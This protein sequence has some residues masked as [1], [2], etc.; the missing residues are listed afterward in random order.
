VHL[1]GFVIR[2]FVTM[3]GHMNVTMHG[4]MNV[5]LCL[6]YHLQFCPIGERFFLSFL[7]FFTPAPHLYEVKFVNVIAFIRLRVL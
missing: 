5:K 2:E 4:H 1:V 7:S 6:T 3:H